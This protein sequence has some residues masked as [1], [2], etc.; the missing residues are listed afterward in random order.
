MFVI[1]DFVD[2]DPHP[3]SGH[4]RGVHGNWIPSAMCVGTWR[5]KF[6]DVSWSSSS[7]GGVAWAPRC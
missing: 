2:V 3:T 4:C 6:V 1:L 7:A 5:G